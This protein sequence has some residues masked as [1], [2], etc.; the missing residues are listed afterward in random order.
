MSFE[1][2]DPLDRGVH[3]DVDVLRVDCARGMLR[4]ARADDAVSLTAWQVVPTV[5]LE[6]RMSRLRIGSCR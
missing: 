4:E 6:G 1:A 3:V 2:F 5:D